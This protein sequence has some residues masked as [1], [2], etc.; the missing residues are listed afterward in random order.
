MQQLVKSVPSRGHDTRSWEKGL[1]KNIFLL[2]LFPFGKCCTTIPQH[3]M[4]LCWSPYS[5]SS[6]Q[7]PHQAVNVISQTSFLIH[8]HILEERPL[9]NKTLIQPLIHLEWSRSLKASLQLQFQLFIRPCCW[10][11]S[12][13]IAP[14]CWRV[15]QNGCQSLVSCCCP[16]QGPQLQLNLPLRSQG[17]ICLAII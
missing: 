7:S 8:V 6:C 16:N 14:E 17:S 15:S 11:Y 10:D 12:S 4:H 2:F 3:L 9:R 1:K 5:W 13:F